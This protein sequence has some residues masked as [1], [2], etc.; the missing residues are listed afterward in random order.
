MEEGSD[1]QALQSSTSN[2]A[3]SAVFFHDLAGSGAARCKS[4]TGSRFNGPAASAVRAFKGREDVYNNY[5]RKA[6]W[7]PLANAL[8]TS[9]NDNCMSSMGVKVLLCNTKPLGQGLTNRCFPDTLFPDPIER[10]FEGP[11]YDLCWHP[12]QQEHGSVAVSAADH[13]VRLVN[14]ATL[15]TQSAYLCTN[16]VEEVVAPT[17][18]A[19][20]TDGQQLYAGLN[21]QLQIFQVDRPGRE[22]LYKVNTTPSRKARKGQKGI[23]SSIVLHPTSPYYAMSS[24][25]SQIGIYDARTNEALHVIRARNGGPRSS[26]TQVCF[27]AS[28]TYLLSTHR[29]DANIYCVDIRTM[30]AVWTAHRGHKTNQ[31]LS[32][33]TVQDVSGTKV[34]AA[35][36]GSRGNEVGVF[37]ILSGARQELAEM[38]HDD[39]V[40][41]VTT[42]DGWWATCSGERKFWSLESDDESQNESRLIDNSLRL[43]QVPGQWHYVPVSTAAQ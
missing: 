17:A 22:A 1:S 35:G 18:L 12:H 19:F 3:Y 34:V 36:S 6:E 30:A 33:G 42:R 37:D 13:G 10:Q 43:W 8:A 16:H 15:E 26:A 5:F 25:S 27:D 23:I 24:Y 32:I 7:S 21:G 28:G 9:S 40:S 20:S 39:V 11:V 4:T 2:E 31:R 41:W 38:Q 14:S 29:Q